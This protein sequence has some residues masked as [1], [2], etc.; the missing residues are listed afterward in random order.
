MRQGKS[1]VSI[2]NPLQPVVFSVVW[3]IRVHGTCV[4]GHDLGRRRLPHDE[5]LGAQLLS[6]ELANRFDRMNLVKGECIIIR[7]TIG[8]L[9]W[10]RYAHT[11]NSMK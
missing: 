6:D 2:F 5:V 9:G 4:I 3:A 8:L 7:G 11:N 10:A 1:S